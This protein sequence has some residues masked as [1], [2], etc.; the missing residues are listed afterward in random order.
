MSASTRAGYTAIPP[1]RTEALQ[2]WLA[3]F[4]AGTTAERRKITEYMA[5]V[6][7]EFEALH[8]EVRHT[9]AGQV[10]ADLDKV[11]SILAQAML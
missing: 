1:A 5:V 11:I 9:R 3:G 2:L 10:H 7:A 6:R 4:D 8:R